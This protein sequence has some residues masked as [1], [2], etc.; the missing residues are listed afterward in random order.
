MLN[1]NPQGNLFIYRFARMRTQKSLPAFPTL[2]IV[3]SKSHLF[4]IYIPHS[5]AEAF[6]NTKTATTKNLNDE[7][8]APA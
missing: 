8:V 7:L 3:N 2:S 1:L 6:A 4:E 5:Q